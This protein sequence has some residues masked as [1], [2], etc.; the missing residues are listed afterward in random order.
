MSRVQRLDFP[1]DIALA[2]AAADRWLSALDPTRPYHA[3]FSGGRIAARFFEAL[4]AHS[5]REVLRRP[6]IHFLFAD[7]RCV[8]PDDPA[9]NFRLMENHLLGPLQIASSQV[10][11][12][13]GELPPPAAAQHATDE[14]L[15]VSGTE[16][17]RIPRLDIVF[18]GMGEDGHVASVFPGDSKINSPLPYRAV[19]A[20]KPP[21]N[22]I[23]L[24]LPVIIHAKWVWVLIS[25][26]GKEN[27]LRES[28]DPDGQTPL[29]TVLRKRSETL[30]FTDVSPPMGK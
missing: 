21:P 12:I 8:P 29:A 9:S 27:A 3:A 6:E 7:E 19:I 15:R 17:S 28:L 16:V 26:A 11:R 23:T 20:P 25:G 10:H 22:R 30:V 14:L 5:R 2:N 1:N 4:A 18:L 13:P 24:G